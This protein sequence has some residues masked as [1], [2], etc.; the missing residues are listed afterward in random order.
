MCCQPNPDVSWRFAIAPFSLGAIANG[1]SLK[2]N[3]TAGWDKKAQAF[4][5]SK[6]FRLKQIL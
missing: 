1:L 6:P 4:F 5:C 3:T 2:A